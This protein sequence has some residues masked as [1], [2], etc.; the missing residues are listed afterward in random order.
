M[1]IAFRPV[2]GFI[3]RPEDILNV[4]EIAFGPTMHRFYRVVEPGTPLKFLSLW[5]A[6]SL[7]SRRAGRWASRSLQSRVLFDLSEARC[8]KISYNQME[9]STAGSVAF[10]SAGGYP[11]QAYRRWSCRL[12]LGVRVYRW[13]AFDELCVRP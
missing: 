4:T 5:V 12:T 6:E 8:A 13:G 7:S 3:P 2:D 1:P 11:V 10:L 9:H